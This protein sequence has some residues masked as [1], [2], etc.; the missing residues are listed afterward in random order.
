MRTICLCLHW[1]GI[2][3]P[4]VCIWLITE[5]YICTPP[6][7][8]VPGTYGVVRC[9]ISSSWRLC[10]STPAFLSLLFLCYVDCYGENTDINW[11]QYVLV[12]VRGAEWI[13]LI[14]SPSLKNVRQKWTY[15]G[16]WYIWGGNWNMPTLMDETLS[17]ASNSQWVLLMKI[18]TQHWTSLNLCIGR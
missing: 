2:R 18:I 11:T 16:E 9:Q 8:E 15:R 6:P 13:A 7:P 10:W 3:L 4:L 14:K 1:T 17:T 5:Y 12:L